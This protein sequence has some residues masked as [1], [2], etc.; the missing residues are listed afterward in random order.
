MIKFILPLVFNILSNTY[1]A[2]TLRKVGFPEETI[3]TMVC[4]ANKESSNDPMALNINNNGSVDYG[5]FQINDKWWGGVCDI[6]KMF[7][8]EENMKCAL[9]VYKELGYRGWIAYRTNKDECDG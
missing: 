8:P 5:L 2:D 9:K 7:L 4:I 6:S 1:I 3:K